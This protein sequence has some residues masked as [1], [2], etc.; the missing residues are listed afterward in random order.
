MEI[1]LKHTFAYERFPSS[2]ILKDNLSLVCYTLVLT[3]NKMTS[4]KDMYV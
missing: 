4:K 1:S 3:S 2:V